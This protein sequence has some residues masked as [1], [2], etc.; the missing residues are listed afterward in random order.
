MRFENGVRLTVK[1]TKFRDDEV[2]VR[3]NVGDGLLDLPKD[4]TDAGLGR[5]HAFIEGG[6]KQIR[7]RGHR[8]GA[9]RP[10]STARASPSATTPSCSPARTRTD[11][12]PTQMQVLAAY[13]A[14]PGWR[15]EAFQRMQTAGKTIHDQIEAHRR[16]A[17]SAATLPACCTPAT[18]RWTFPSRDEIA[19]RARQT[20][21]PR[22]RRHLATGPI[23]V[24]VVGDI[25]VDKAIE[26][27]ARTFGALPAREPRP[28]PTRAD[29]HGLPRAQ[30]R[31]PSC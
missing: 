10:R 20:C 27:V 8:A 23:E 29:G 25:T 4:R 22:S 31:S 26:A 15:P 24:V 13:V 6:L 21:R 16:R 17:C 9:G 18:A 30:R 11:D 1:P 5:R 28:V 19:G 12:L 3:V 7:Q 2:L 14:D